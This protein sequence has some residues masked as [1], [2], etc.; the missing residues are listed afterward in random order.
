MACRQVLRWYR[1]WIIPMLSAKQPLL[2]LS[3]INLIYLA[4]W[5]S[6]RFW[7]YFLESMLLRN[8][9]LP[10]ILKTSTTVAEIKLALQWITILDFTLFVPLSHQTSNYFSAFRIDSQLF[11]RFGFGDSDEPSLL[12][13]RSLCGLLSCFARERKSRRVAR[14]TRGAFL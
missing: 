5:K 6:L 3:S 7:Y 2:C 14:H 10:L 1:Y 12:L 4:P 9:F 11:D 8:G 13:R